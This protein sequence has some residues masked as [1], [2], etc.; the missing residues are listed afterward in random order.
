MFTVSWNFALKAGSSRQGKK[1]RASAGSKFVQKIELSS[2]VDRKA[3]SS[4][5][6]RSAK[7]L[8]FKDFNYSACLVL[9][10]GSTALK[11]PVLPVKIFASY[12]NMI[13][14]VF[15]C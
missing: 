6:C 2:I 14:W 1:V 13:V 4:I 7:D 10:S 3:G 12:S 11:T 8:K 9:I 5:K 15:P